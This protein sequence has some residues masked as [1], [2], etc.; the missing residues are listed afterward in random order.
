MSRTLSAFLIVCL[1]SIQAGCD[2]GTGSGTYGK[3]TASASGCYLSAFVD[4]TSNIAAFQATIG[5]RLA[6]VM[7][8]VNFTQDFPAADAAVVKDNGSIAVITWE[9]WKSV[10]PDSDYTLQ[11]IT[12]G[13]FDTYIE[14]WALAARNFKYP[15]LLRFAH[16]MN[17][18]WYPWDGAHNGSS[19]APARFIAAWKHVHNIFDQ[20]GAANVTWVWDVNSSSSPDVS[21]NSALNYYPGDAY[22]DWVA[23]DG[24]NWGT[25]QSWSSW[26][27]FDGI[28]LSSYNALHAQ[29]PSKPIM[30]GEFACSEAGGDKATWI[31]DAFTRIKTNYPAV[32]L[33]SWFDIN[34]ATETDW[35]MESS[36]AT[37][38]A[39]KAAV[40]DPYFI[41][42]IALQ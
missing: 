27:S 37:E 9:P 34:K 14:K 13:D 41:E 16:E 4:G 8:Y 3:V 25:S 18:D 26:Q 24:Y 2:R 32:K 31:T 42:R 39:F 30:I 15:I 35:R 22:V 23:V 12:N 19:E 40:A 20:S 11:K 36:V 38:S 5:K 10:V 29:M 17:G 28:F 6:S 1:L 7:W 33:L 21:W